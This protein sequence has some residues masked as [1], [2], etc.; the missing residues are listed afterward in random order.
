MATFKVDVEGY[1]GTFSDTTSL[2]TWLTAAAKLLVNLTPP[3]RLQQVAASVVVTGSGLDISG[4]RF[5]DAFNGG[6]SCRMIEP[7]KATQAALS[8]SLEYAVATSPVCYVRDTKLYILPI[9]GSPAA[10]LVAYPT[11]ANTDSAVATLPPEFRH[12]I[13]LYAAIQA[14]LQIIKTSTATYVTALATDFTNL[15]TDI[16]TDEDLEKAQGQLGRISGYIQQQQTEI[17]S[18]NAQ[19]AAMRAEWD[20]LLTLT[21]GIKAEKEQK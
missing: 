20:K 12:L 13:V 6:Y 2:D 7:G 10:S 8:T 15:A 14:K 16:R 19:L 18:M 11:V 17:G 5:V 1:V 4:Y 21:L 9:A 3:H